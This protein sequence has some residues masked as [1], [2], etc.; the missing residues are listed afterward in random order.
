MQIELN[1][2]FEKKLKDINSDDIDE[3]IYTI[4]H[5]IEHNSEGYRRVFGD[6][7]DEPGELRVDINMLIAYYLV[8]NKLKNT[9]KRECKDI[10]ENVQNPDYKEIM[11]MLGTI[12]IGTLFEIEDVGE[13]IKLSQN[14]EGMC[15]YD[16]DEDF[17]KLIARK[18]NKKLGDIKVRDLIDEVGT[19]IRKLNDTMP[20]SVYHD[21]FGNLSTHGDMAVAA[22][23]TVNKIINTA[24]SEIPEVF[25]NAAGSERV[26]DV[27]AVVGARVYDCL[28]IIKEI[29]TMQSNER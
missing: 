1:K 10:A 2:V 5:D 14:E 6:F 28:A 9:V 26:K 4:V 24:M 21:V 12:T 19:L 29:N 3:E 8:M 23:L 7:D 13:Q 17:D 25:K 27:M 20:D 11:C 22:Y 16:L 15:L 18:F